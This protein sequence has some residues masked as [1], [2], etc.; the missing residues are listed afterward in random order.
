MYNPFD[1]ENLTH[2]EK[3]VHKYEPSMSYEEAV[4]VLVN[5]KGVQ[6]YSIAKLN[7]LL[8]E[9]LKDQVREYFKNK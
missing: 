2:I 8:D 4:Q 6:G 5:I 3:E 9:E 7:W 1:Q